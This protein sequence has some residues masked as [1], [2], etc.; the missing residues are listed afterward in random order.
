M[1]SAWCINGIANGLPAVLFPLFIT[2]VLLEP[3]ESR[4][5][6]LLAYFLAA[7]LA[8][9]FVFVLGKKIDKHRLWC[10]SMIFSCTVFAFVPLLGAGDG[11]LFIAVC[12]LTGAALGADLALPPALLADVVD[13]DRYRFRRESTALCFAGGSLATKLALGIAVLLAPFLLN[14]FGWI[15]DATR[16]SPPTTFALAVI[17]AWLPC[18]LKLIAVTLLWRYPLS[19]HKH[20]LIR[21][22]LARIENTN[23]KEISV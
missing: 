6:Y 3:T 18:V 16:Q 8:M 22:R 1:V 11:A 2:E 23:A 7:V 13:W 19:A 15:D 14:Q 10:Y 4:G 12:L 5:T 9:P 20:D 17:Y 21:N